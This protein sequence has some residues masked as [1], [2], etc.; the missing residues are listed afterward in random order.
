MNPALRLHWTFICALKGHS[1]RF[2]LT[3][4]YAMHPVW[5]RPDTSD[6]TVFYQIFGHREYRC[7][8]HVQDPKLIIDCGANV[9]YSAA[10]FLSRFPGVKLIAIEP[11]RSNFETLRDNLRPYENWEAIKAE[12]WVK[13]TNLSASDWDSARIGLGRLGKPALG[14]PMT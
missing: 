6:I 7:L 11:D 9:G 10:Y 1:Q 12:V 2:S 4:P 8:D 5:C 3:S 14:R 13:S